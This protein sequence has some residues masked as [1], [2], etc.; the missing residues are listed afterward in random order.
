MRISGIS[1]ESSKSHENFKIC[2]ESLESFGMFLESVSKFRISEVISCGSRVKT[3]MIHPSIHLIL[4]KNNVRKRLKI[5]FFMQNNFRIARYKEW[6]YN[7]QIFLTKKYE[8]EQATCFSLLKTHSRAHT[9]T[10][11]H[12]N[13]ETHISPLRV[14][15]RVKHTLRQRDKQ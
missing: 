9:H 5:F 14:R 12:S 10:H 3:I 8:W 4:I 6:F 1:S 13:R 11:T 15:E 7:V 2:F